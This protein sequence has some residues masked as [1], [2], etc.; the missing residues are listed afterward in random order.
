M[1]N[2]CTC[3]RTTLGRKV[4][5]DTSRQILLSSFYAGDDLR[6]NPYKCFVLK[7][8]QTALMTAP[9]VYAKY[10]NVIAIS[11]KCNGDDPKHCPAFDLMADNQLV[12]INATTIFPE[13]GPIHCCCCHAKRLV[14]GHNSSRTHPTH[15]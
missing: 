12:S 4:F 7:P 1:G 5:N 11:Y 14:V 13:L 6:H 9:L 3:K 10:G 15:L 2:F 8:G